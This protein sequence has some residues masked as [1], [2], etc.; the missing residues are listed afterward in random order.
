MNVC[1]CV[2]VHACVRYSRECVGD[3]ALQPLGE[4]Q[5]AKYDKLFTLILAAKNDETKTTNEEVNADDFVNVLVRRYADDTARA[6]AKRDAVKAAAAKMEAAVRELVATITAA[7]SAKQRATS[8]GN[9]ASDAE[10]TGERQSNAPAPGEG[11]C[12]E[13]FLA[14][15]HALIMERE[16]DDG[17]PGALA[18]V[19]EER[20]NLMVAGAAVGDAQGGMMVP[21]QEFVREYIVSRAW[22]ANTDVHQDRKDLY[23]VTNPTPELLFDHAV[24]SLPRTYDAEKPTGVVRSEDVSSLSK[25]AWLAFQRRWWLSN[26]C[27]DPIN[28]FA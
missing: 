22:D 10:T 15:M 12:R 26:D 8:N 5:R 21:K 1:L 11:V 9:S 7:A 27:W 20:F 16:Y 18:A 13:S 17:L 28:A 14:G 24:R 3:S 19:I 23:T 4:W 2:Y 25:D 6:G